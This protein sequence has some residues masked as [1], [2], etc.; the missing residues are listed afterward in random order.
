MNRSYPESFETFN[1]RGRDAMTNFFEVGSLDLSWWSDLRRSG[2][3][4]FTYYIPSWHVASPRECRSGAARRSEGSQRSPYSD[5]MRRSTWAEHNTSSPDFHR[6]RWLP[7]GLN[8]RMMSQQHR[9]WTGSRA[10]YIRR[11]A[12]RRLMVYG[13]KVTLGTSSMQ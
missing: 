6:D 11:S 5:S 12:F 10:P 9:H 3:I 13:G 1:H 2:V 8:R 7:V 4:M